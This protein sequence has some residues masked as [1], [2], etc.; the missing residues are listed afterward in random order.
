MTILSR[1]NNPLK[2]MIMKRNSFLKLGLIGLLALA[3]SGC[4]G[5]EEQKLPDEKVSPDEPFS[6]IVSPETKTQMS[7][8]NDV[9][10][11]DDDAI[12]VF[13]ASKGSS[14]FSKNY[15]FERKTTGD[16][17]SFYC[18]DFVGVLDAQNDWYVFYP[19]TA[20]IGTPKNNS[21][22]VI[23]GSAANGSQTQAG[24]SSRAHLA[25][26][27]IP[28]Y[29]KGTFDAGVAPT[30][31]LDQ[32]LSVIKVRVTNNTANDLTVSSVSFTAPEAIV[33]SFAIDFSGK[34]PIFTVTAEQEDQVSTTATLTV[35][36][37]SAIAKGKSADFYLAIKPF[38]VNAGGEL[39]LTVNSESRTLTVPEGGVSFERGLIKTLNFYEMPIPDGD[40]LILAKN[41]SNYYALKAEET[42]NDQMVSVDYNGDLSLFYGDANMIWSVTRSGASY[43]IQNDGKYLGWTGG[44]KDNK[45]KFQVP[46]ESW[47]AN[48]YLLDIVS[49]ENA[50]IYNIINHNT[51]ERYLSKHTANDYFAFYGNTGQYEEII[52]V[53]AT[54]DDRT[55][56][57]LSFVEESINKTTSNYSSFTGQ[58]PTATADE[59]EVTGLTF[60]YE[61]KGDSIGSVDESTGAVTLNGTTGSA[62]VTATFAGNDDY[63][64]ATASYTIEVI[65]SGAVTLTESDITMSNNT[66]QGT[67][68]TKLAYRLGTKDNNG[69]I[70]FGSGYSTITFTL[71]GWASGTRSFSITNGKI[72]DASSLS[73]GA[74]DPSGTINAGFE[75]DYSGTEYTIVVTDPEQGVVFSGRRAIVW[76]FT[77]TLDAPDTRQDAGM[78]WSA[79]EATATYNTGNSLSFTAPTLTPGYATGITYE[80]TEPTIATISND[81][82]VSITA[83]EGNDVKVGSTTIKAIFAGDTDYKP[84][85]VSYTLTVADNRASVDAPTFSPAAGEVAANTEVTISYADG[86]TVYYTVNNTTPTTSSTEYTGPI[87]IDVAKTI[88]AIATKTGYKPSTVAEATYTISGVAPKGSETNPYTASEAYDAATST[89]VDNVYVKG[90]VSEITTVYS[91][92]YYN[93]TF[94]ISDDGSTTGKQFTAFR[95][96]STYSS[97]VTVGDCVILKGNLKLYNSTPE[98]LHDNAI[99]SILSMPA[100]TTGDENFVTSTTVTLSAASGATIYYT[101]DGSTPTTSSSVY[102]SALNITATTTIKAIAVKDDL[103]TGVASKTF[104]KVASYAITFGTPSNGTITV[105]H[106]ETTLSSGDMVPSGETITITASPADGYQL[107]TLVYNDGS[108]HDIK[109][110]KSFTMPAHAV[111]VTATFEQ[112][113]GKK[114]YVKVSSIT[115]GK[116]Y[117]IVGGGTSK[118]LV[119]ST[120][121]GRKASTN[122]TIAS[123]K[124]ESTVDVDAN[125]VT[126]VANGSYYDITFTS[127]NTTY[128]LQYNSSTNLTATTS[129]SN[130]KTWD[131]V[132]GTYGTFRFKDVSTASADTKRGLVFRGG[133]TNQFG[134]YSLSNVNGSEYYDI[135]LYE[136][137]G[138]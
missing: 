52:F 111:S 46:G 94:N 108:D 103:V 85:T 55:P 75:T 19:Y 84:Q 99:Q 14:D 133:S 92:Q 124:I 38:T 66:V 130:T 62:T 9:V 43:I 53:P 116:R 134:G 106:G 25:G 69:S 32:A 2:E 39:V 24:N 73:P 91:T 102:S 88:K 96:K 45:A 41:N 20:T 80:S 50:D 33:G 60:T 135:D 30:I 7:G 29:G 15:K 34:D 81:G 10:W 13:V 40:Y 123:D 64:P 51:P 31:T 8:D 76:G 67:N 68:N 82:V 57:T 12:T 17:N 5:F 86:A 83:L 120:G 131:V 47:A 70:T 54:V 36:D 110:T 37:G 4:N 11:K 136:Y 125:A 77:A 42:Q 138:N 90:I 72:N 27:N 58:N 71:A 109:S 6:I 28:L 114:Y 49:A 87:T 59:Q 21:V 100:F 23:V 119:P 137:D 79:N 93:V 95:E 16:V 78:S 26:D 65:A 126:I 1:S 129:S 97:T 98:L 122:V 132:A 104:N 35:N 121:S 3:I 56:L 101:N 127:A 115:S 18:N 113:A 117:L 48:N 61:I 22:S 128:Y 105:K 118:A 112:S 107:S 63:R 89:Q 74:G 44:S